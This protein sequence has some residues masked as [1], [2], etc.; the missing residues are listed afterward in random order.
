MA[1]SGIYTMTPGEM[2]TLPTARHGIP[3]VGITNDFS[4]ANNYRPVSCDPYAPAGQQRSPT[5]SI[6]PA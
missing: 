4:G 6:P 2:V 1:A 5:G 3:G